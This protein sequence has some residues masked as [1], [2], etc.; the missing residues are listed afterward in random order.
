MIDANDKINYYKLENLYL[1]YRE[2]MYREANK[3]LHNEYD[4]EDAVQIAFERLVNCTD[5]ITDEIPAMTCAF[6]KIVAKN[7][8]VNVCKQRLYLNKYENTFDVLQDDLID[9]DLELADLV[10]D[11]FSVE[12]IVENIKNLP[13]KYRD[14][15]ILEKIYGYS[16]EET[17]ALY[18]ENYETIKRRLTRA[19]T[20]L[21]EVLKQEELNGGRNTIKS[22]DH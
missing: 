7:A 12:R 20:K 6:M 8:A 14:I 2:L 9:K 16:R 10:I 21:L 4:A 11:K 22:K 13:D 5:K 15:I 3:V 19:K 18:G 1:K 17:M